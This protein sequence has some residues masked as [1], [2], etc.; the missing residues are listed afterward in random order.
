MRGRKNADH[1]RDLYAEVESFFTGYTNEINAA[2]P[3]D[4]MELPTYYDIQW[5]HFSRGVDVVDRLLDYLNKH[6]GR[7]K[8]GEGNKDVMTV[9]NLALRSWKENVLESLAPRLGGTEAGK[10]CLEET[11]NILA[12]EEPKAEKSP[13]YTFS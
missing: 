13:R 9:K 6:Y 1:L 2:A 12:A 11:R 3:N 10:A 8:H 5:G 4:D 7:R